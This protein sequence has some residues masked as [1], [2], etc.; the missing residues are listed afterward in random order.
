MSADNGVYIGRFL[1]NGHYTYR[2][3]HA[4][5]IESC[6]NSDDWPKDVTDASRVL[7]FGSVP[8]FTDESA[9]FMEA[10]R[11]YDEIM[12]GDFPIVEYGISPIHYDEPFPSMTEDEA[13]QI[14]DD[15]WETN[16]NDE[17]ES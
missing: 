12:D 13:R 14:M 16:N 11:I 10:K 17:E 6:D 5:A 9:A 7:Y 1:E 3:A 4:Q 2:V 8:V 15:L